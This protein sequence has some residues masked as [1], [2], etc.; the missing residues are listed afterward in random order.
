MWRKK[1]DSEPWSEWQLYARD[2]GAAYGMENNGPLDTFDKVNCLQVC[3]IY[4]T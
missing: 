1:T 3:N 2:C 4:S